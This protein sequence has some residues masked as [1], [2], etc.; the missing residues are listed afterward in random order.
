MLNPGRQRGV[1]L[2]EVM[3]GVT[4]AGI[5]IAMGIPA[6][7]TGMQ[8]RQIRGTADAIQ[9]GLVLA[10]TEALRRNRIVKF[11]LGP[12]GGTW[13]V[14][15]ESVDTTIVDGQEACP[16]TIQSRAGN[17][18]TGGVAVQVLQ[19]DA[20]GGDPTEV[21]GELWLNAMGRTKSGTLPADKMMVFQVT[22]PSAGACARDGGQLRCLNVVMTAMGQV[23]MCDPATSAPDPR[24]CPW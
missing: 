3:I 7:Q 24:A 9:N 8:N 5:L 23:R 20:G 22:H 10:R 1:S 4:L 16:E 21:P 13:V 14:G 19:M 15:C 6:F 17:D 11:T 12:A 2:V 18:T